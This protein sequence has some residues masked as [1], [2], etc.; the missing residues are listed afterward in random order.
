[1]SRSRARA[2]F[3]ANTLFKKIPKIHWGWG[4]TPNSSLGTLVN[5][6]SP[7]VCQ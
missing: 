7:S 4:R 2:V 1:M 5:S 3:C 6:L